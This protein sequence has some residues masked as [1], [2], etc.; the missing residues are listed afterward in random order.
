MSSFKENIVTWVRNDFSK[1]FYYDPPNLDLVPLKFLWCKQKK[2]RWDYV[3][4]CKTIL[5]FE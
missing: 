5:K 1:S 4:T 3:N 2:K